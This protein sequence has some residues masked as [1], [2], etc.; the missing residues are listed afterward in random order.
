MACRGFFEWVLKL[1]NLVVMA[2]GMALVGYGAYLLV[3]WLQVRP[4]PPLPPSPAP[5]AV[6]LSG[7]LVRLRRPPLLLVDGSLSDATSERLSSAW[8]IMSDLLVTLSQ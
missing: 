3:M 7:D 1:L 5:A 6:V 4:P 8:C 2:V